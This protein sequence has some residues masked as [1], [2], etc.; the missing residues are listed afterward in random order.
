M[1]PYALTIF[2]GAFLVFQVQPLIGKYILPWFGGGP[3]V[4]TVCL[5][6]FQVLLLGGY[7]Y[8]HLTARWLSP[9]LQA[10]VHGL[11]LVVALALL[12]I[13][14]GD[15]WKP[16]GAQNPT[17][18]IVILLAANLGLP[19][20][21]LS[22][23]GPLVQHWFNQTNPGRSPYRLYALSNAGS[24]LALL[25]YPF[26]V[27][28][29]WSRQ[30]QAEVWSW[31]LVGYALCCGWCGWKLWG[32]GGP[33][34]PGSG[35]ALAMSSGQSVPAPKRQS[36]V[37]GGRGGAVAVTNGTRLLWILLP[38]CA[39][40]LLLAVTN[41]LCQDV[42]VVPFLWVLPLALYL[43]SFI[44]CF[45]RPAWYARVPFTLILIAGAGAICAAIYGSYTW[46]MW[47][48]A[49]AFCGGLF[50]C[51][52]VCH[53][54]LYR[55]R[56]PPRLLTAY[57]LAIALGG[58]LGGLFVGLV[59]PLVFKGYFELHAGLLACAVLFLAVCIRDRDNTEQREWLWLASL[60]PAIALA[61]LTWLCVWLGAQYP[62]RRAFFIVLQV[63]GA[64]LAAG[65]VALGLTA[66]RTAP[67]EGG[68][69]YGLVRFLAPWTAVGRT[70]R[71]GNWHALACGWMA[72][73]V[74]ALGTTLWLQRERHLET[75]IETSRN[76]FGVLRVFELNPG[77]P[78]RHIRGLAHGRVAHGYEFLAPHRAL[79]PTLYYDEPSGVGRAFRSL[80]TGP[81]RVG[82]V[83]LG[84]GTLTAYTGAGDSVRVYEIDPAVVRIA[85]SHFR[86]LTNCAARV[87]VVLG[88]AR[89]A[90]ERGPAQQFD[91]L[92]LDAFSGDAI[93]VHLLTKEA[94]A[95]FGRHLQPR[96]ILAVHISNRHLDLEPVV[97]NVARHLGF[98][99]AIVDSDPGGDEPGSSASNWILLAR[100]PEVLES[101][102][103]RSASRPPHPARRGVPLWTDDF[104][105]LAHVLK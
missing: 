40:V 17:L 36:P 48:L 12:P 70:A 91:L 90:L 11:L 75:I 88:D 98:E 14:P 33:A 44:V 81:K 63:A 73:A 89:L 87:D 92:V 24:L 31:G 82:L 27:E 104:A 4:W 60:L 16:D 51:C 94:F 103:I 35:P 30:V 105:S 55:L 50:A 83:G 84:V 9:R 53:G 13:I 99:T 67:S 101:A 85:F 46:P 80:P 3:G 15:A 8:A 86:F 5:L 18:K 37:Q 45:D 100:I 43:V 71:W 102:E 68:L 69:R 38:A 49:T 23:T 20:F 6:F 61:G 72:V 32:A 62:G 57:Y 65:A 26:L 10:V 7:A 25:S 1:M 93:P 19:F 78:E 76:F 95:L 29:H 28:P 74:L 96:G 77:E 2:A 54:E 21:V 97:L 42:A 66:R 52:M 59:A 79:E 58:A 56:P 22:A 64:G 39:S 47:R 34:S 41:S